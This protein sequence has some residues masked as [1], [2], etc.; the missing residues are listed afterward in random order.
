MNLAEAMKYIN[1]GYAIKR[2]GNVNTFYI[3]S[4]FVCYENPDIQMTPDD[5][6][7]SDWEVVND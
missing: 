3:E 7:A 4:Q 1:K 5:L 6:Q 2:K